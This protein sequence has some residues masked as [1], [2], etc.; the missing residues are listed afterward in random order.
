MLI[1]QVALWWGLSSRGNVMGVQEQAHWTSI[2]ALRA[3]RSEET[4]SPALSLS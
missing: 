4:L 1:L 3:A 2:E